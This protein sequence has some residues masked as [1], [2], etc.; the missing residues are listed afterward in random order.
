MHANSTFDERTARSVTTLDEAKQCLLDF[1]HEADKVHGPH[2][3]AEHSF[4]Y[5]LYLP[6]FMEV[7][8]FREP[9]H[10]RPNLPIPQ[11]NQLYMDAAWSLVTDGVLRPGPKCAG[12]EVMGNS[13]GKAYSLMRSARLMLSI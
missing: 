4:G 8:E 11:L 6:W 10:D 3:I 5:D 13:Y 1:I 9:F 12:E 7:V 2:H